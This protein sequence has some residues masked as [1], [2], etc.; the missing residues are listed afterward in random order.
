MMTM[1]TTII[2]EAGVNHDGDVDKAL[3]LVEAA[4]QA[5]A[6]VVKFQTFKAAALAAEEAPKA[7]YQKRS[8]DA[9]ES[10]LEMLRRLELPREAYQALVD[11]ASRCDIGFLSTPFDHDSLAFLV[12]LGL[13]R[14]KIGSGDL[15][16]APLLLDLARSGRDVILSSGMATL[17]EIEEALSVLAYG[18]STSN[19]SP[20]R[21]AF[22]MAWSDPQARTALAK[23][24][25]L[26]HCTTEY[27]CPPHDANL[28]AMDTMS[29]AFG[30][31]VG[32]SD[33]TDG[34]E[35]ALAAVAR[36]ACVIE[37][38]LTLD[39]TS[40]GPDHAASLE[41]AQFRQMTDAIRVVENALGDGV[42][43][44]RPSEIGNIP[45]A[46]KSLVAARPIRSG[47]VFSAENLTVK[48]PGGE[49]PPIA[50][51]DRLGRPASR[52]YQTDEAI[53]P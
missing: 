49:L 31:P 1:R 45:V 27:P 22:G 3:A 39:R 11:R 35:V 48:R 37:K 43:A 50:Y 34:I 47:E 42:K 20:S 8:T 53:E 28:R 7:A 19:S 5:G 16:N 44:P 51:W 10:Q 9:E 4:K 24:V 14:I 30:L 21:A 18:Y 12:A 41:P 6:D 36:G 46:R 33:H 52:S 15:T 17:G 23:H 32:F 40:P 38:H 26:L 13:K 2:A 25:T 29:H